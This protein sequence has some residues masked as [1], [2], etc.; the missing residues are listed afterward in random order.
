MQSL[1]TKKAVGIDGIPPLILKLSS[2]IITK[3][4]TKIINLCIKESTFPSLAKI[5]SILPIFKKDDRSNKKNYRPISILSSISKIFGKIIHKQILEY[6]EHKLSPYISAYRQGH[7]TQHVLIR[8]IEEWKQALDNNKFVGAVLMDL[9][10]AFDCIPHDLLIAKLDAYGFKSDSLKLIYSYLKGRRQ[11]VK[12]NNTNSNFLTLLS[13]VPQGSIVG[14]LLFNIFINDIFFI[15]D[16]ASLHG[17]AYDNTLSAQAGSVKELIC[18]L[19]NESKKAIDWMNLNGMLVN[20]SKFQVMILTKKK[21]HIVETLKID[22]N[23]IISQKS[24]LLL[25]IE[26]DDKLKFK[27]HISE[28]CKRAANQLN[29]LYRFKSYLDEYSRRIAVFSFAL[30]NF[31][32]CPLV[33]HFCSA[34][35]NNKIEYLRKRAIK[36][37]GTDTVCD[38]LKTSFKIKRLRLLALEI[39]KTINNLN[40]SYINNIFKLSA[41]RNSN[42][43]GKN[44]IPQKVK[45]VTYG[46]KVY[47]FWDQFYGT[48][49]L[50]ILKK[51]QIYQSFKDFINKWGEP[52]CPFYEKFVRYCLSI[53]Y[54]YY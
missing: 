39:F 4:L 25:G 51:F 37:I 9:L 18:I 26:I 42:R 3:P 14:P 40:P 29:S 20:S 53:E 33:W 32:Y 43:I 21:E 45:Q 28:L 49:F 10:K 30:S 46:K 17:F 50:K 27:N 52:N 48:H 2:C 8:L 11:C 6:I 5:A 38:K 15:F 31:S 7:S 44:L 22:G 23:F 47:V 1:D 34:E 13:G 16:T 36:F 19:E 54:N 24:V 35:S 12:I 41:N